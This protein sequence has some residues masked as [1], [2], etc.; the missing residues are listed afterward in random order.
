MKSDDEKLRELFEV[1][2]RPILSRTI[3]KA[4]TLSIMRSIIISLMIIVVA[5]FVFLGSN[6]TALNI[7]SNRKKNSLIDW[8]N[9]A[10]PNAY[11]GY[12]QVNDGITVGEINYS[13]FR[14]LGSKPIKDG[15]FTESY[16]Y[17]PLINNKEEIYN[18]IDNYL[19][20]TK[21]ELTKKIAGYNKSGKHIM[22]FY[23]PLER[24]ENYSNDF[25]KLNEIDNNKLAE[26]SLSF[27]KPYSLEEVKAMIPKEVTLNW[28]WVDTYDPKE[29]NYRVLDEYRVYGMKAIDRDGEASDPSQKFIDTIVKHKNSEDN[30]HIYEKIYNTLSGGNGEIK[31]DDLKIIGVVV[32]GD[33]KSLKTLKEKEFIKAATLGAVADKY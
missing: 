25:E 10:M 26:M 24:F 27:D 22:E 19:L 11:V 13:R 1:D 14:F 12:C 32:S 18:G 3:R 7:I 29:L 8:Y 2:E 16:T 6:S 23:H 9:I 5:G 33:V 4:K 15:D 28:Y 20:K 21:D 30:N 31:K 17:V